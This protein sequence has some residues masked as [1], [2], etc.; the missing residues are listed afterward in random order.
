[1]GRQEKP[2]SPV[3]LN[4][5]LADVQSDLAWAIEDA[6]ATLTVED[7]PV[8]MADATQMRQVFQNVIANALKYRHRERPCILTIRSTVWSGPETDLRAALSFLDIAVADNGIGFEMRH[9]ERI[10]EPFQ[11]LH[12]SDDYEGSGIG[13]AICRKIMTRHSGT[14]AVTSEPGKGSVFTI[15]IPLRPLPAQEEQV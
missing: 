10:F 3:D 6:G 8:V 12:G 5:V 14:I 13:L 7:L 1:M 15:S 2:L 11:R 4:E 9:C